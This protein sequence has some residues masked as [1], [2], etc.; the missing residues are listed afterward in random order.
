MASGKVFEAVVSIAGQIDPSLEKSISKAQKSTSGLGK[1][2][3]IAGAVGAAGVVAI[4]TAAVAATKGLFDLGQ[5]YKDAS[6]TIRI[7]TGA[8]GEALDELNDSMKEVYQSVPTSLDDASTAIADLNTRLG[9][10]GETLE[11]MSKQAIEVSD[12][13]GEDMS[14]TIEESSQ[15]FKQWNIGA[16]DMSKEMDYIYKLS[17]STGMGFTDLMSSVQSSGAVLQS[18]GY[19]FDEAAA[20]IGNMDKAGVNTE[21]VLKGMK[22]GLGNI[23]KDGGDAVGAMKDYCKQIESASSETE[24]ITIATDIFGS[25]TAVTMAQA[26][27]K[28]TLDVEGLTKS[29]QENGESILG[30]AEDTYTLSDRWEML[31]SKGANMLEPMAN[32]V[33]EIAT[34]AFPMLENAIDTVMPVLQTGAETILPVL[35]KISTEAL[36]QIENAFNALAPVVQTGI[37][38]ALPILQEVASSVLPMFSGMISAIAPVVQTLVSVVLGILPTVISVFYKIQGVVWGVIE[39]LMPVITSL[40]DEVGGL[41]EELV[42]I[43]MPFIE[44]I[45]DALSPV[46]DLIVSSIVPILKI[47]IQIAGQ[48]I[49]VVMQVLAAVLPVVT[50]IIQIV[51]ELYTELLSQLMP[52]LMQ[53]FE[54]IMPIIE[55][56]TEIISAILPVIIS[57]LNALMPILK[58]VAN[59]LSAVLGVAIKVVIGYW[60]TIIGAVNSAINTFKGIITYLQ[61]FVSSWK[62]IWT[63]VSG[64]V[65]SAFSGLVGVV[66]GPINTIIGM[67]NGVINKINGAGFTIPDWVPG[68]GGKSFKV[69][70]ATLPML[71]TGG[72]TKG[73]SIAGEAG[74]ETVISYDP[75]FRDKNIEYWKQAGQ[76]LGIN[77]TNVEGDGLLARILGIFSKLSNMSMPAQTGT[78]TVISYDPRFRDKNIEYWKQ[79]GQIPGINMTNVEGD[80]LLARILG[81]FSKL[82]NMSMSAQTGTMLAKDEGFASVLET[83]NISNSSSYQIDSIQYNPTIIIQGNASEKDVKSALTES[84]EEFF[85]KLDEWWDEKTG[86]GDYEP[87]FV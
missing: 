23:A 13:L 84:K 32:K 14:S 73:P 37:E 25:A 27:R 72:H 53:I 11:T 41:I 3:K 75:R 49:R 63:S 21:Q 45:L 18:L 57:I 26:I 31:K 86:G 10:T 65:S 12:M 81:I 2:L 64:A 15:A 47:I 4:G 44:D 22:K 85:D 74:T 54:A 43:V 9:L 33:L 34:D 70:V 20:M 8:T 30:A 38:S 80:G 58:V 59:I 35:E 68:V 7:G 76:M 6:N 61:G 46:I 51:A 16:D 17:Q 52:S 77:M 71:A 82:S 48:I 62:G 78:E 39:K 50:Q 69:S 40:L 1:G 67:V 60:N 55:A 28:G 29:L 5:S 56:E 83:G 87:K 36:P 24:A 19:S 66:K 42:G 79:A